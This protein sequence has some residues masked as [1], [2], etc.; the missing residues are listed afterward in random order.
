[1]SDLN[2]IQRII[3]ACEGVNTAELVYIAAGTSVD[4]AQ[5]KLADLLSSW[6]AS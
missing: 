6:E 3:D 5:A 2:A 4:A 1:M